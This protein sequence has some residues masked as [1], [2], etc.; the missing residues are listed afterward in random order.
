MSN[1]CPPGIHRDIKALLN[2]QRITDGGATLGNV[3]A[4]LDPAECRQLLTDAIMI[5]A[6][7]G[8]MWTTPAGMQ[9]TIN[10][11][12]NNL[13]TEAEYDD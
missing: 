6:G 11:N 5:I 10:C 1:I 9:N 13:E 2:A 12:I 3:V 8:I 7:A 4:D